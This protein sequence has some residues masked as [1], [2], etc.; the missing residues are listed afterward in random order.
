MAESDPTSAVPQPS[1]R[2]HAMNNST[3]LGDF[4]PSSLSHLIGQRSVID[5]VTVAID[6]AFADG[7]RLDHALL[8]GP[9][10]VGKSALANVLAAEMATDLHEVLG[11]S[12]SSPADLN[13]LLLGAKPKDVI[14]IDEAHEMGKEFQTA[15]YLAL[16]KQKVFLNGG[17]KGRSPQSIPVADFTLLLSTTDEYCL[18]QPLRDR[19]KLTLRFEF[20]SSEELGQVVLQRCRAH[21]WEVDER[22]FPA[23]AQRSRGT[24]RLALRLLQSC[25]RVCRAEGA[26]TITVEH[27]ERAC[28]LEQVDA[29]GLGVTEQSY[30]RLLIDGPTRLNVLASS[31]GLP[32]RT[33]SQVAEPFLI[34]AGLITKDDQGRRQLTALGREHLLSTLRQTVV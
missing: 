2:N 15:L 16:D 34:R 28:S 33:V 23:I 19:M 22:L 11:Q 12:V 9:P 29:L 32:S 8:V 27:L 10:G 14:H 3:D 6:A 13:A 5:Q 30:L 18:L 4:A 20:Y 7:K 25:R 17:G 26:E 24:P 1:T 31:L 21:R